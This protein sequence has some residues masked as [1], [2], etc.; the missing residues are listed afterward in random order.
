MNNLN[1]ITADIVLNNTA[2][3]IFKCLN[4]ISGIKNYNC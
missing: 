4:K 3:L 2:G 1:N